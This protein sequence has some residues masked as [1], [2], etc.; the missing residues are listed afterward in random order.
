[1]RKHK[2]KK[3]RERTEGRNDSA[4]SARPHGAVAGPQDREERAYKY[5]VCC[6]CGTKYLDVC[7][8]GQKGAKNTDFLKHASPR[9]KSNK[10]KSGWKN[11]PP[12]LC[13]ETFFVKFAV[14]VKN[15]IKLT[16]HHS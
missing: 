6:A 16:K 12:C 3:K 2:E 13:F 7:G 8:R 9:P 5:A 1:M 11:R 15:L 14:F 10:H 4:R